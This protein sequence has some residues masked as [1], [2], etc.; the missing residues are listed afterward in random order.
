VSEQIK[1]IVRQ[2]E[3]A[4]NANQLDKLDAFFARGFIQHS[5]PP[6]QLPQGLEGS[7]M[8]HQMSMQAMPDRKTSM[9]DVIADGDQVALRM[10]MTG[11]NKGGFSWFNVPANDKLVDVKWISIYR[12]Q[13]G[14]VLEHRAVMDFMALMQQLGAIPAAQ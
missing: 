3:E 7:K 12:L 1:Q 10:R 13:D 11:T 2:I 6:P 8:T 4:W 5:G 9:E 14:K